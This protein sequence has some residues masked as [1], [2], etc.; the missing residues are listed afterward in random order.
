MTDS[1]LVN[2]DPGADPLVGTIIEGTYEV[3]S[4]IG[5]GGMGSVYRANHLHLDR[6]MALKVLRG[7]AS[8]GPV[9][10]QR[11]RQEARALNLLNHPNIVSCYAFGFHDDSCYL[12][13]DFVDGTTLADEIALHGKMSSE[14]FRRIFSQV[15]SALQHAHTNGIVHRDLKPENIMLVTEDGQEDV[16]RLLDFGI[17]KVLDS[18][19]GDSQQLTKTGAFMGSPLF[20]SPEQCRAETLDARSDIYSLGCVMYLAIAGRSAFDADSIV[21]TIH[22]QLYDPPPELPKD[23]PPQ[24]ANLIYSCLEKLPDNRPASVAEVLTDLE[25]PLTASVRVR[26]PSG[27]GTRSANALVKKLVQH[28]LPVAAA[29]V[30]IAGALGYNYYMRVV[31]LDNLRKTCDSLTAQQ[32]KMVQQQFSNT[33]PYPSP[34]SPGYLEIYKQTD[35]LLK[36]RIAYANALLDQDQVS[37]AVDVA[38][39]LDLDIQRQQRTTRTWPILEPDTIDGIKKLGDRFALMKA[40]A[41]AQEQAANCLYLAAAGHFVRMMDC[42]FLRVDP[43]AESEQIVM[44]LEEIHLRKLDNAC[45]TLHSLTDQFPI[46]HR[47]DAY[48]FAVQSAVLT[49]NTAKARL[50]SERVAATID[51]ITQDRTCLR[52]QDTQGQSLLKAAQQ[53]ISLDMTADAAPLLKEASRLCR[54]ETSEP[55]PGAAQAGYLLATLGEKQHQDKAKILKFIELSVRASKFHERSQLPA[56]VKGA[57]ICHLAGDKIGESDYIN[58]ALKAPRNDASADLQMTDL[59][60]ATSLRLAL[61]LAETGHQVEAQNCIEVPLKRMHAMASHSGNWN[62]YMQ[63]ALAAA[64]QYRVAKM[65]PQSREVLQDAL[66]VALQRHMRSEAMAAELG[67]FGLDFDVENYPNAIKHATRSLDIFKNDD[68]PS[69]PPDLV[70]KSYHYKATAEYRN[71]QFAASYSDVLSGFDYLEKH[72]AA[73]T[74]HD[75]AI[76]TLYA[77]VDCSRLRQFEEA[78]KYLYQS[79]P[80]WEQIGSTDPVLGNTTLQTVTTELA[81]ALQA[82]G[83]ES[84]AKA[85]QDYLQTYLK[86]HHQK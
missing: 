1:G 66:K 82:L 60:A 80:L 24:V 6:T 71:G 44:I 69:P 86:N 79:R 51:D 67:L 45:P 5:K 77:G 72:P 32:S 37:Q 48:I 56:L 61:M 36:S 19:T 8:R 68:G 73:D 74:L 62:E 76:L 75:K 40:S 46:Q 15:C 18:E 16:V 78:V 84:E 13:M 28:K 38:A 34:L 41:Q 54:L 50:Y 3:L 23:V 20:M 27:S 58:R 14:R 52:S 10:V 4:R 49:K 70:L 39:G 30:L 21:E 81:S 47:P 17:A 22:H 35:K 55:G 29:A 2:S 26:R 25:S 12:V 64:H 85:A 31:S 83:R 9:I 43:L 42:T 11:F 65:I 59:Q 57:E 7:Y 63:F 33:H 53:L